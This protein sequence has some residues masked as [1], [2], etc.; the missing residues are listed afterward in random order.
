MA[1]IINDFEVVVEPPA[2]PAGEQTEKPATAEQ[3][4][5][6]QKLTPHDFDNILRQRVERAV[7]VRAH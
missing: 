5:T 3:D 7:R 1:V 6:A 4:V 2:T